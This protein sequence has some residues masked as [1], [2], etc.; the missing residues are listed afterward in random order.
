MRRVCLAVLALLL[1]PAAQEAAAQSRPEDSE[2]LTGEER[3]G[4]ISIIHTP[5]G[6][7]SVNTPVPLYVE[8][9]K[10]TTLSRVVLRYKPFGGQNY[11]SFELKKMGPGF[12]GQ[13]PCEDVSTTGDMRYFFTLFDADGQPAG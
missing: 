5:P 2:G 4:A 13:I 11:K 9:T 10:G 6:E 1:A 3:L 12:G 7:Q 8:P